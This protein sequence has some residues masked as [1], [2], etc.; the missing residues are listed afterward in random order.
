MTLS[1]LSIIYPHYFSLTA[2][3]GAKLILAGGGKPPQAVDGR[4]PVDTNVALKEVYVL[5]VATATWS[6]LPDAPSPYYK[7]ICAVSAG[8]LILYGGYSAHA[9]DVANG[10]IVT[11]GGDPS[12]LD[13]KENIWVTAYKPSSSTSSASQ[14][15]DAISFLSSAVLVTSA[16]MSV[17]L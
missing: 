7:P 1:D 10:T 14:V 2:N 17:G 4:A 5:D 9:G 12:I 8:S 6:K 11:N 15:S 3:G 13:L 16:I